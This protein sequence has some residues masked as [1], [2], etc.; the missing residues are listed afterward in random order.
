MHAADHLSAAGG[1]GRDRIGGECV[2]RG[3]SGFARKGARRVGIADHRKYPSRYRGPPG[4]SGDDVMSAAEQHETPG[5]AY[6]ALPTVMARLLEGKKG[7]I[8]G[9][10][11]E[12]SIAW[13]CAKAFRSFGAELALTYLNDKAKPYVEPLARE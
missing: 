12:H 7:L 3:P 1:P 2:P 5:L 13:G 4:C 8:V 11:N 6:R 9:I 10:A